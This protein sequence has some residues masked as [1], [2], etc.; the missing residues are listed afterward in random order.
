MAGIEEINPSYL[1]EKLRLLIGALAVSGGSKSL[2]DI[3]QHKIEDYP[4]ALDIVHQLHKLDLVAISH[5]AGDLQ[6][7]LTST[8]WSFF[9]RKGK[10]MFAFMAVA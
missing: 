1:Q 2:F 5:A 8:G 6:I 3:L 7:E 9:Q 4:I 10:P